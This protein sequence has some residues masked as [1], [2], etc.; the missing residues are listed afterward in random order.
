[1][2]TRDT[3][4]HSPPHSARTTEPSLE[5]SSA[6]RCRPLRRLRSPA[7]LALSL[8]V[9]SLVGLLL[10]PPQARGG[11]RRTSSSARHRNPS[12]RTENGQ[13]VLERSS[14]P[15]SASDQRREVVTWLAFWRREIEPVHEAAGRILRA[16]GHEHPSAIPAFCRALGRAVLDVD[17]E[18]LWP[19]PDYA[20]HRHLRRHLDHLIRAA[21]ACLSGRLT[22]VQAELRRADRAR[23]QAALALKRYGG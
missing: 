22:A 8:A 14:E 4:P 19:A 7:R 15:A 10:A 2:T 23:D 9:F 6:P 11:D 12:I 5:P 1:M 13:V 3:L 20:V 16:I 17:Q 21:T 18:A